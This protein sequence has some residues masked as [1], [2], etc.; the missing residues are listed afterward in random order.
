MFLANIPCNFAGVPYFNAELAA[1]SLLIVRSDSIVSEY[2]LQDLKQPEL[3]KHLENYGYTFLNDGD[4]RFTTSDYSGYLYIV[5]IAPNNLDI[6]VI[7]F[8]SHTESIRTFYKAIDL[9]ISKEDLGRNP[10]S[11]AAGGSDEVDFVYINA[12]GTSYMIR[13]PIDPRAIV[14]PGDQ[15]P[16]FQYTSVIEFSYNITSMNDS[17]AE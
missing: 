13:S 14:Y 17:T 4:F 8:R 1:E 10:I 9:G 5:G 12:G 6:C 3:L 16:S 15:F 11:I 7:I 2:S